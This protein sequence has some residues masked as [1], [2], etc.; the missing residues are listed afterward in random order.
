MLWWDKLESQEDVLRKIHCL[1]LQEQA[2]KAISFMIGFYYLNI[3]I[4]Q[5]KSTVNEA[6]SQHMQIIKFA[7][8]SHRI[9][10]L[11]TPRY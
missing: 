4:D 10:G 7:D 9:L 11:G 6:F 1:N 8:P 3:G 5:T 2:I